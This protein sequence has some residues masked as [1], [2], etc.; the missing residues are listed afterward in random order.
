MKSFLI[1][2]FPTVEAE[3]MLWVPGLVHRCQHLIKN[4]GSTVCAPGGE[5]LVV[6]LGA[7]SQVIALEEGVAAADF[8]FAM[9]TDK[10]FWMPC[11]P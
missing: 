4:G 2:H 8:L 5:K 3:E 7:I 1:E 9:S 10:M 6:V 11:L